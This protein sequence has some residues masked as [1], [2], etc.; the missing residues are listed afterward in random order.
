MR[1]LE[2]GLS[3][4]TEDSE[5]RARLAMEIGGLRVAHGD[6]DGLNQMTEAYNELNLRDPDIRRYASHRVG[7]AAYDLGEEDT[8]TEMFE[9]ILDHCRDKG[10]TVLEGSAQLRLAYIQVNRMQ[11]DAAEA[12]LREAAEKKER[13]GHDIARGVIYCGLA[14]VMSLSGKSGYEIMYR[15]GMSKLLPIEDFSGLPDYL[16][17]ASAIFLPHAP[18]VAAGLQG[19]AQRVAEESG[20]TPE[21]YVTAWALNVVARTRFAFS[22]YDG[23]FKSGR[24]MSRAE[25]LSRFSL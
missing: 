16:C 5:L 14:H 15:R 24:T 1:V 23:W 12:N 22:D 19:L 25:A 6:P 18:E 3:L 13:V 11:L 21:R 17:L 10:N 7:N 20:Y 2:G 4:V 8:A 9:W